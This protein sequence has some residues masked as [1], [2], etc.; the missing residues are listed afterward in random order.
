MKIILM[1]WITTENNER[2]SEDR[3][4]VCKHKN[5]SNA[6]KKPNNQT[7][8]KLLHTITSSGKW[9]DL[10]QP[11]K[12]IAKVFRSHTK[13]KTLKMLYFSLKISKFLKKRNLS[14]FYIWCCELRQ[15][16]KNWEKF[17]SYTKRKILKNS[18]AHLPRK[19]LPS[20][21]LV[22]LYFSVF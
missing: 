4:Y 18:F 19:I 22:S 11:N 7:H 3:F 5:V 9:S 1:K 20:Q 16:I 13:T 10:R 21:T 17:D 14:T 6:R 8:S 15:P 2:F 12:Y